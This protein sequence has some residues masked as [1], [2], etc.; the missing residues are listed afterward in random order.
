VKGLSVRE[1]L[2]VATVG[3]AACLGRSE[4][5]GRVK[6][7]F[8]ADMVGWRTDGLAFAG[9]FKRGAGLGKTDDTP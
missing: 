1:A 6:P 2:E 9:M 5:V 7:G 3:G 8:V 4:D